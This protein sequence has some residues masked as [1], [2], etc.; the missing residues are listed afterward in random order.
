MDILKM[1]T[2][3]SYFSS[4]LMLGNFYAEPSFN[5]EHTFDFSCNVEYYYYNHRSIQTEF[6]H[7]RLFSIY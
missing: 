5:A 7:T 2:N 3:K 4:S 6:Y 1:L